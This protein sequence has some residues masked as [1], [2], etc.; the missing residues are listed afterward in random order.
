MTNKPFDL[1]NKKVLCS[2]ELHPDLKPDAMKRILNELSADAT[3]HARTK[4]V[5]VIIVG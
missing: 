1:K 3:K 2:I 5:W 4:S